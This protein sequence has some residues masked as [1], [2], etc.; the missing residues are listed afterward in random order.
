MD[1]FSEA[2]KLDEHITM[3]AAC[4]C[5]AQDGVIRPRG[6]QDCVFCVECDKFQYNAPRAETGKP[7]RHVK[8]RDALKP[9]R[10][11]KILL[12]A[13]GHC[14]LCGSTGELHVGHLL[15]VDDGRRQGFKDEDLDSPENT[16]AMCDTC[17]LGL[18][19]ETVPLRFA[20]AIVMA[21][22]NRARSD[23]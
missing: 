2:E 9:K 8:N 14:E 22:L 17:N 6:A 5:G 7:V 12:R 20:I 15:S 4:S 10:R 19:K 3:R 21:R 1:L 18:G 16:C 11:A 13:N 23:T